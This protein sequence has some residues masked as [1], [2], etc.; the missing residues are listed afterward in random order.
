MDKNRFRIVFSEPIL[1]TPLWVAYDRGNITFSPPFARDEAW[2][3]E[4]FMLYGSQALS[5]EGQNAFFEALSHTEPLPGESPHLTRCRLFYQSLDSSRLSDWET[6]PRGHKWIKRLRLNAAMACMEIESLPYDQNLPLYEYYFYG[7]RLYSGLSMNLRRELFRRIEAAL[8]DPEGVLRA[9]RFPLINYAKVAP[10][11]KERSTGSDSG[12]YL[13]WGT[14][15]VV[16]GGW[17]GRDGGAGLHESLERAF[18]FPEHSWLFRNWREEQ[19]LFL[20]RMR[21]ALV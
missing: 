14:L 2:D 3:F 12:E 20:E 18:L 6:R 17:E 16:V 15:G 19:P 10:H 1:Q 21:Q 4:R 11:Y 13:Q 5:V 9:R 7:M 8:D